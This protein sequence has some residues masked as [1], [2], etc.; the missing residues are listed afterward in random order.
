MKNTQIH[1]PASPLLFGEIGADDVIKER[2]ITSCKE[3]QM[4][5]FD[6]QKS[7]DDVYM[8]DGTGDLQEQAVSDMFFITTQKS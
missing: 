6:L 5:L 2:K 3:C 1:N 8:K 4:T 7:S